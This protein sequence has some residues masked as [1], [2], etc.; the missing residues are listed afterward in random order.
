MLLSQSDATVPLKETQW[1]CESGLQGTGLHCPP[2]RWVIEFQ[3]LEWH[4]LNLARTTVIVCNWE[5]SSFFIFV[6]LFQRQ[7]ED[8]EK[9]NLRINTLPLKIKK[10]SK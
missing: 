9:S 3:I 1:R 10:S 6:F 5:F 7:K 2:C 8:G 4:S